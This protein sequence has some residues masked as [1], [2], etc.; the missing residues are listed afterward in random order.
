MKRRSFIK[1]LGAASSLAM[2]SSLFSSRTWAV[3]GSKKG[4]LQFVFY[5]DIHAYDRPGISNY[6]AHAA[7]SINQHKPDLVLAG[8]DL[9]SEGF[10]SSKDAMKPAWDYYMQMHRAINSDI[11]PAIGNHDLVGAANIESSIDPR[12]EFRSHLKLEK[13]YYSFNASGYHFIVLDSLEVTNDELEYRGYVNQEQLQWLKEDLSGLAP[14]TPVILLTHM[15][16]LTSF[17]Q[18][19]VGGQ[20]AAPA[21]R[22]LVNNR[23]VLRCFS[24]HNLLL[25]LQGHLH[26]NEM[27][28]W[29][30]T[31]FITGGA[32]CG[33]WW[34]GE[35]HGTFEG[36]GVITL[37]ENLISW[38]YYDL[39][40]STAT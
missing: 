6:L 19:T 30:S 17:F 27:L 33:G 9:V 29:N 24:N 23:E 12:D 28:V 26:I 31:R 22:V 7:R 25:V 32:I 11:Y 16:L 4:S 21:N 39:G 37:N 40:E 34:N 35:W 5:T 20:A 13:T 8:G 10:S 36:Y 3:Q 18:A 2:A 1:S 14:E 15:P 38:N